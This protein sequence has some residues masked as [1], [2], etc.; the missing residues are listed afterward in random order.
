MSDP[1]AADDPIATIA[2][3][4]EPNR[5]RLYDLV[6]ENA[7]PVGRDD[8]AAALGMSRELAAFHLDRLVDAGLL[9]TEHHRRGTRTGPGAGRPAKFYRRAEFDVAVSLP[10]RRY[11]LAADLMA[12]ALDARGAASGPDALARVARDR[13][14]ATGAA[15]GA[16]RRTAGRGSGHR[17]S[18]TELIEI[19]SAAGFQPEVDP[20]SGTVRLRNCP[21]NALTADHRDLTCGM[22]LAWAQGVLDGWGGPATV[23]FDPVPGRCCV[24]F[25]TD[26]QARRRPST[27][28]DKRAN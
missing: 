24:T 4:A 12:T 1:T 7:A 16:A 10:P 5:Q 8:A 19:L 25:Q 17:P 9:A 6:V 23:A 3:L 13:G 22:N 15:T 28:P 18:L 20:S 27:A 21:Y 26:P 11:D 14:A 2:L